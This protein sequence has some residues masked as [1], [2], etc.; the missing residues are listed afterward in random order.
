MNQQEQRKPPKRLA[1]SGKAFWDAISSAVDLD[2]RDEA[3][4]IEACRCADRLD[5]LDGAIRK[6]G[7]LLPDGRPHPALAEARQQQQTL[8]RLIVALRLPAD[9]TEPESRPQRRGVR[10]AYRPRLSVVE[11]VFE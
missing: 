8:A 11:G 5:A 3:F 4:L 10:G 7:P 1:K 9:L 6:V 2:K